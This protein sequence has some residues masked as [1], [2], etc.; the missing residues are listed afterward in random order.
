M[1]SLSDF[2]LIKDKCPD[3]MSELI[4]MLSDYNRVDLEKLLRKL[5]STRMTW[6][7]LLAHPR[8]FDEYITD[9]VCRLIKS[10]SELEGY[11]MLLDAA[12][13]TYSF[14]ETPNELLAKI[15]TSLPSVE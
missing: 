14:T 13:I 5:T 10:P 15:L 2:E 6:D 1:F 4:K 7:D 12:G 3:D 11:S 9:T 8:E